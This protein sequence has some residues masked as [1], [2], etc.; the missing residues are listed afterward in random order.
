LAR[1]VGYAIAVLLSLTNAFV[2]SRDGYT[3]VYPG[4]TLSALVVIVLLLTAWSEWP[5]QIAIV[6]E[7]S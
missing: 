7:I 1:V 3:A 2:H 5:W 4:L 6:L